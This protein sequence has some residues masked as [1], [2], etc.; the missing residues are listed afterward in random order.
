MPITPDDKNW[1]WVLERPCPECGFN[2]STYP[3]EDIATFLRANAALWSMLLAAPASDLRRRRSD[4]RWS[5]LEYACHV[6][7][8]FV[9]F[10]ERLTLMLTQDDPT[11]PNWDQDRT[12]VEE[13][14]NDQDPLLVSVQLQTAA[15]VLADT[16]TGITG[17]TW[18]RTG[19]R[20]DGA[21]FTITEFGRYL[22]HDPVHHVRDVRQDLPGLI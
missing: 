16:F 19:R 21:H 2:A 10:H 12:A 9:L 8:V 1:T 4:G 6:R 20:S 14:Y 3:T 5:P 13:R 17:A 18:N 7:D 22:V 11:Y 15:G